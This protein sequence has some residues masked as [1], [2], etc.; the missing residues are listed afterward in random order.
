MT[1]IAFKDGVLAADRRVS[2]DG[3]II[4]EMAKIHRWGSLAYA[5]CGGCI[6][7]EKFETW[8]LSGS[9]EFDLELDEDFTAAIFGAK[10]GTIT[11]WSNTGSW[12]VKASMY[13][14][15]SG[16]NFA[17]GAMQAGATPEQAIIIASTFDTRTG[18]TV[19]V[20]DLRI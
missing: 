1:T 2:A 10:D 5:T 15:G 6:D 8:L 13:A 20:I 14:L 17:L 12:R 19:D 18:N 9:E 11:V 7:G 3:V 4:G 16:A